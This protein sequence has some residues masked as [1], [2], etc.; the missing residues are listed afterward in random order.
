MFT[1]ETPDDDLAYEVFKYLSN[2]E[3]DKEMIGSQ[4]SRNGDQIYHCL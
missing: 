3:Q 4:K 1:P 2:F